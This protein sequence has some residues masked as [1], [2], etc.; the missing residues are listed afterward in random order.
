MGK[1]IIVSIDGVTKVQRN[2]GIPMEAWSFLYNE[3]Y[4]D[5]LSLYTNRK[6]FPYISCHSLFN[7]KVVDY[8]LGSCPKDK[9][10]GKVEDLIE[11]YRNA[12]KKEPNKT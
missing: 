10:T 7:N 2:E 11:E 4:V 1:T 8:V 12:Q 5:D 9:I 3:S 6:Y